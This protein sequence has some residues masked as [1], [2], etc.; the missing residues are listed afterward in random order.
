MNIYDLSLHEVTYDCFD[1]VI[2]RVPGGWIYKELS[3][4]HGSIVP[5]VFVPYVI[6]RNRS[7]E[8]ELDEEDKL[9]ALL[10][11]KNDIDDEILEQMHKDFPIDSTITFESRFIK[12]DSDVMSGK[13]L[14]YSTT[15]GDFY[16]YVEIEAY[17]NYWVD[18]DYIRN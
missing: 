9:A 2:L 15:A 1:Y 16:V 11:K 12:D 3:D 8:I 13:V 5:P 14:D 7:V 6:K 17:G 10:N 18:L 4:K